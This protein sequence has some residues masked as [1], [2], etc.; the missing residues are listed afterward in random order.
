MIDRRVLY[1]YNV[2]NTSSST[3]YNV[4]SILRLR[5]RG[6][7]HNVNMDSRSPFRD[8]LYLDVGNKDLDIARLP[9][10]RQKYG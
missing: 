6:K 2:P 4:D 10:H 7:E 8:C 1:I 9:L 3:M 5:E